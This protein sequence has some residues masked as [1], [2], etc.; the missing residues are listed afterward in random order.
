MDASSAPRPP[1]SGLTSGDGGRL[2]RALAALARNPPRAR[3]ARRRP[4]FG[5]LAPLAILAWAAGC[6]YHLGYQPRP[7]LTSIAV[8]IAENLSLRREL[9]FPL[10]EAIVREVQRRTPLRVLDRGRADAVLLV[11]IARAEKA[12]LVEGE[13]DIVEEAG[14][15]IYLDVRLVAR[16]GTALIG[17]AE[18]PVR[19]VESSEFLP[20]VEASYDRAALD[21]FRSLAERVVMLLE[22]PIGTPAPGAA[23]RTRP[24]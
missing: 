13:K 9:E 4:R 7:G 16:D 5:L 10:T 17:T 24:R 1:G 19:L 20:L 8:P 2:A 3:G 12:V 11:T 18:R 21:A 15:T 14:A 23:P 22:A 6:G